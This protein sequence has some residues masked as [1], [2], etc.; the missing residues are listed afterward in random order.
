MRVLAVTRLAKALPAQKATSPDAATVLM[1]AMLLPL[2][3]SSRAFVPAISRTLLLL[4]CPVPI[5]QPVVP[6][7]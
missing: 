7:M 6:P 5:T 1:P 2:P 4:I 3:T